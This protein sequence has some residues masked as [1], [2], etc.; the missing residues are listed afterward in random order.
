MTEFLYMLI[1]LAVG[2]ATFWLFFKSKLSSIKND[3]AKKEK[4]FSDE[5]QT[6]E[7]KF[8]DE[9]Q[10]MELSF[11]DEKSG[12]ER[13]FNNELQKVKDEFN[14]IRLPLEKEKSSLSQAVEE[15]RAQIEIKDKKIDTLAARLE[16]E[17]QQRIKSETELVDVQANLKE[18]RELLEDAN[19]KLKDTFESLSSTALKSNNQSFMELARAELSKFV[20]DAKG[21]FDKK[22]SLISQ[23]LEPISETL[24]KYEKGI[25]EIEMAREKAYSEISTSLEL[26][27]ESNIGLKNETNNLVSVLKSSS[28]RGKY[29]EIGLRRVVEYAGLNKICDFDEQSSTDNNQ[30]PDLIINL[31]GEHQI[32]VDSKLPFDSYYKSH[33]T[34][35]IEEKKSLLKQHADAVKTHIVALSKKNYA[36]QYENSFD[37]VVLY[38]H[39]ESALAAA[40]EFNKDL[41]GEAIQ[42]GIILATPTTLIALLQTVA[43]SWKQDKISKDSK[44]IYGVA[45]ELYKRLGILVNHISNIGPALSKASDSYNNAVGSLNRNYLT[46]ARRMHDLGGDIAN[47]ELLELKEINPFVREVAALNSVEIDNQEQLNLD[48]NIE[49]KSKK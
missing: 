24:S 43:Y 12:L 31:P 32:I 20:A 40:L 10:A 30:R 27:K 29:G 5:Q 33:E 6:A 39:F 37:S 28:M 7:R 48:D 42:K 26:M 1:G 17:S 22:H 49:L 25:K 36:S 18:Q 23:S 16:E 45:E 19:K 9:K 11:R 46:Q 15:I 2:A 8:I 13:I 4:E 41:L 35:N 47:T 3:F 21:D 34:D 38:I 44:K 14:E